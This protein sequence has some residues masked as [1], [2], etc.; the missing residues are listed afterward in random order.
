MELDTILR[1]YRRYARN[2]DRYFGPILQPGRRS[3]VER[4]RCRAGERILEVGVGTGLS[5]PL[6]PGG[7]HVVGIDIS[8]EMLAQAHARLVHEHLAHRVSL[9]RMDAERMAF[10]DDSF[11]KVVAM[12]V[13]SVVP[14]PVRL[15]QEM[16]RVC[17][18]GGQ[19]Y[20]VNHFLSPYPAIALLERAAAPLS[21]LLGFRP[22]LCLEEFIARTRLQVVERTRVNAFG[23]WTLLRADNDKAAPAGP[24]V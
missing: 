20:I 16:R 7:V 15:V 12:Y 11:D 6:Y 13:V 5:L 18:P 22:N 21:G 19:L 2:Y 14:D 9:V 17:R 10:A 24:S 4:L 1:T 23:L 3:I 8:A